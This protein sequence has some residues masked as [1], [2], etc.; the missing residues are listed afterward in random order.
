MRRENQL[1]W[2]WVHKLLGGKETD[3]WVCVGVL[4][5][6]LFSPGFVKAQN[7]DSISVGL[8]PINDLGMAF[9]RGLQGGLYPN[10]ENTR[11][12]SHDDA[13][14]LISRGIQPLNLD[15]IPDSSAGKI[16]FLSIGMS[17]TQQ[18]FGN[19]KS[20]ADT[21]TG[22]NPYLEIVNG[23]QGGQDI[24]KIIDSTSMFWR[25]IERTL[26]EV[27]LS[28][29]QVQVIW[30]K[31]AE[32]YPGDDG[33]DTAFVPYVTGLK[34]KFKTAMNITKAE[35]PNAVLCYIASRIYG[36]YA[37]IELNDEPFAHY[38][39]WADKFLIED[40]INGDP[41]LRYSGPEANSPW[42][43][44]GVYLWADGLVPRSDGL[45]WECPGDYQPDGTHPSDPQGRAK[46]ANILFEFLVTDA[47][48]VPWFLG[49]GTTSVSEPL[50]S[51]PETPLRLENYPNP[52]NSSAI[53]RY[54]LLQK[55]SVTL[56]VVDCLGREVQTLVAQT[57]EA[58]VHEVSFDGSLFVSGIYFYR[59]EAGGLVR[60]GKMILMR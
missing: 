25:S 60:V 12:S 18:E 46:V 47:T 26:G 36:G 23:A 8:V 1:R 56:K 39:G 17:N 30:F 54:E 43:S 11:P 41:G 19:F 59:L 9:Y 35:F 33:G 55:S 3:A 32:A 4:L 45:T 49:A 16:V 58:G 38:T 27:G 13:G 53:I 42:L 15:G 22:R 2:R 20:L 57:E 31:E 21:F 29:N 28:N 48:A 40:Q 6:V 51:S 5:S 10:G 7:C 37:T 24:D 50:G 44:W 14:L 34:E 52:F